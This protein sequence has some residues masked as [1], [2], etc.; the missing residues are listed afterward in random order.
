MKIL[1][2]NNSSSCLGGTLQ[3]TYSV[4]RAFPDMEHC[5]HSFGGPFGDLAQE[6]FGPKV[7]L[8]Q[9]LNALDTARE[10][11]PDLVIWNNTSISRMPTTQHFGAMWAYVVH[12]KHGSAREAAMRCHVRLCVSRY[13]AEAGGY[14][15]EWVLHQPVT[16]P[17]DPPAEWSGESLRTGGS[18]VRVGRICTPTERK[19]DLPESLPYYDKLIEAFPGRLR[20]EFVAPL[21]KHFDIKTSVRGRIDDTTYE[22]SIKARS[23][24][25]C[26]DVLFYV[27]ELTETF[28]RTVREAQRSGCVPIVSMRGGFVEQVEG[29]A[30]FLVRNPDD[31]VQSFGKLL[32]DFPSKSAY[33]KDV[34]DRKGSLAVWREQFL[35]RIRKA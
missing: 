26:W 29:G 22:P 32:E 30:G 16:I 15:K 33:C 13:L 25:K 8:K 4:V 28:G 12:S 6:L 10:F 27:S 17:P 18:V 1:H 31:A 24:L 9:G 14:P 21:A 35:D 7:P 2:V 23:L 11:E 3:C 19:W 20:F 5:V 34:G